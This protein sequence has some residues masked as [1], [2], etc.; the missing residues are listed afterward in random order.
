MVYKI[1]ISPRAFKE[2]ENAIDYYTLYSNSAPRNFISTLGDCYKTLE[3]NPHFSIRYKHIRTLHIRRYPYSLYSV[4]NEKHT[5]IRILSCFHN[6]R[7]PERMPG[8]KY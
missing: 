3:R 1:I 6:K 2:I 7:N 5:I 8:L 4:I